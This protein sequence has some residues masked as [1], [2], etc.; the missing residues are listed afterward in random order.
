MPQV[1]FNRP[2]SIN[3]TGYD[4][5]AVTLEAGVHNVPERVAGWVRRN[6]SVGDVLDAAAASAPAADGVDFSRL[7][8]AELRAA[9]SAEVIA[10]FAGMKKAE[11]GAALEAEGQPPGAEDVAA[12]G[13]DETND[14]SAADEGEED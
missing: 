9:A 14:E 6:P 13:A 1:K 2:V 3:L 5:E 4:R 10:G 8:V 12:D 7:T 11:L